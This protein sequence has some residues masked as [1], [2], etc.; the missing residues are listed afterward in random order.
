[1]QCSVHVLAE[2]RRM[3]AAYDGRHASYAEK[4]QIGLLTVSETNGV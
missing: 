4:R 2:I 1:M 3:S